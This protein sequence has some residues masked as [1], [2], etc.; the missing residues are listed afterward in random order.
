MSVQIDG[1]YDGTLRVALRHGPSGRELTTAAPVDN[2]GDGSSFSP[3]TWSRRASDP[4][5]SP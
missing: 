2:Q 5:P 1:R 4:A 3:P